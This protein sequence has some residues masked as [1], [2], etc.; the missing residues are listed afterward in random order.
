MFLIS[1]RDGDETPIGDP[2]FDSDNVLIFQFNEDSLLWNGGFSDYPAIQEDNFDLSF[3][4]ADLPPVFQRSEAKAL[5]WVS[6]NKSNDNLFMYASRKVTGLEPN[7]DYFLSFEV[8]SGYQTLEGNEFLLRPN[9]RNLYIKVG[10]INIEPQ[11][12]FD[13]ETEQVEQNFDKGIS[14]PSDG[15]N[16]VRLGNIIVGE[17]AYRNVLVTNDTGNFVFLT[18]TNDRGELWLLVGVDSVVPLKLAYYIDSFVVFF[19]KV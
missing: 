10:A 11:T 7:A 14:P 13:E 4:Q 6:F 17:S 8:E 2:F 12:F 9:Q 18:R 3:Q 5:E 1:C 16:M 19:R 15:L